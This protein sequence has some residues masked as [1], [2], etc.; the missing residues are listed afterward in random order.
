MKATII[1]PDTGISAEVHATTNHPASQFNQPVWVDNEGQAYCQV[2]L[3]SYF[4]PFY[5]VHVH[6]DQQD[7]IALLKQACSGKTIQ[8]LA[9]ATG[10][11]PATIHRTLTGA[12]AP[13]LNVVIAIAKTVGRKIELI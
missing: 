10:Y 2:G 9:D 7:I 11:S 1:N 5:E 13:N 6:D 12:T 4:P 8:E 3:E